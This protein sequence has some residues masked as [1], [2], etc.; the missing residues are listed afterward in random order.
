MP[1]GERREVNKIAIVGLGGVCL[2]QMEVRVF[3][4]YF[5]LYSKFFCDIINVTMNGLTNYC[6]FTCFGPFLNLVSFTNTTMLN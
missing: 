6:C 3:L 2:S 1:R 5:L 4:L